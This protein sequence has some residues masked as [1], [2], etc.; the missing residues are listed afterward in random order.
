MV[1]R[2]IYKVMKL[3]VFQMFSGS[4]FHNEG[5]AAAKDLSLNVLQVT[6]KIFHGIPLE[7]VE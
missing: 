4:L 7:S 2:E 1:L 6:R 3:S 5:A